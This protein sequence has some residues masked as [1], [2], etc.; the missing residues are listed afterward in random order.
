[1][2]GTAEWHWLGVR[3]LRVGFDA[4]DDSWTHLATSSPIVV[5]SAGNT[6]IQQTTLSGPPQF[7]VS[8]AFVGGY[9]QHIWCMSRRIV[10]QYGLRGDWDRFLQYSTVS[11]L[12]SANFLP[13]HDDRAK[14]T[15][16]WGIL[17][18][19][20]TL[21]ILEPAFDQQF[22]DVLYDQTGTVPDLGS[23]RFSPAQTPMDDLLNN[24]P[25]CQ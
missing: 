20:L 12:V 1:M 14:L 13:F 16:A 23:C 15:A 25:W 6:L 24:P 5:L 22:R 7:R 11:P 8:D 4:S 21:A 19:T 10:F 18:Q 2:F 9:E 3:D 17:V